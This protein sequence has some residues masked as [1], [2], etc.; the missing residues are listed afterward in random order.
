MGGGEAVEILILIIYKII[1]NYQ[2]GKKFLRSSQF[3]K[4]KCPIKS[5]CSKHTPSE[6]LE[7][8]KE[9]RN[10]AFHVAVQLDGFLNS[11]FGS[12]MQT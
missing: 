10:R 6:F 11:D 2:R 7:L 3:D 1:K 5:Q 9:E 12:N 4:S 8:M